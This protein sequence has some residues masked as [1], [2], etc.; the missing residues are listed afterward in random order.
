MVHRQF[1][2][3]PLVYDRIDVKVIVSGSK[4]TGID[5]VLNALYFLL[6]GVED[7]IGQHIVLEH[8]RYGIVRSDELVVLVVVVVQLQ[9]VTAVLE[10]GYCFTLVGKHVLIRVMYVKA[11]AAYL[12]LL[13]EVVVTHMTTVHHQFHVLPVHVPR[14]ALLHGSRFP[15]VLHGMSHLESHRITNH[16]V[17][18]PVGQKH[19]TFVRRHIEHRFL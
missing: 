15:A 4:V 7:A 17:V 13:A 6:H 10:G 14:D 2:Y 8:E 9:Q 1:P 3:K 12:Y 19:P 18:Q 11:G 16:G 5:F